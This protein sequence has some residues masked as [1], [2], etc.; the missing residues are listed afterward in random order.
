MALACFLAALLREAISPSSSRLLR[1]GEAEVRVAWTFRPKRKSD[2]DWT[3][4]NYSS[5]PLIESS[6]VSDLYTGSCETIMLRQVKRE[7]R[8]GDET[9]DTKLFRTLRSKGWMRKFLHI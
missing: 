7:H 5:E 8:R 3:R 1:H 9:H 2:N 4:Q 6:K